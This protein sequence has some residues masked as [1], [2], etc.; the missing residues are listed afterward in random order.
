MLTKYKDTDFN[1][2][3]KMQLWSDNY[4]RKIKYISKLFKA[5]IRRSGVDGELSQLFRVVFLTI[6]KFHSDLLEIGL[7]S[8]ITELLCVNPVETSSNSDAYSQK[9]TTGKV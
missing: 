4:F 2:D 6:T 7:N 8:F 5:E 3:L 9:N 1:L